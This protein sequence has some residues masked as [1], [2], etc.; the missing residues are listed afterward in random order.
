MSEIDIERLKADADYWDE[1]AP[2]GATTYDPT[3]EFGYPSFMKNTDHEWKYFSRVHQK[4]IPCTGGE[5]DQFIHRPSKQE[6]DGGL[7]PVGVECEYQLKHDEPHKWSRCVIEFIGDRHI[8]VK[9][10]PDE[11]MPEF[12][13]C[14]KK[15]E[16]KFRPLKSQQERQREELVDT[17]C[18]PGFLSK[19]GSASW[20]I[21]D[22]I[23]SQYTLEPKQ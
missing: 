13:Q 14:F 2:E 16:V 9:S 11:T 20:E 10:W 23:L 18:S 21:A 3:E 12:E 19:D 15:R 22:A 7:P 8:V 5:I 4:W 17:V 1:V 6:W